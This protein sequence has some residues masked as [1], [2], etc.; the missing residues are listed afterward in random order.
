MLALVGALGCY[1]MSERVK[2]LAMNEVLF[3]EMNER[4]EERVQSSAGSGTSFE[5]VCECANIDCAQRITLTATEYEQAHADPTQF[6]IVPGHIAVDIEEVVTHNEHF[7][8]VR[9]QGLAGDVAEA[10]D[11]P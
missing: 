8:V 2:R 4:V 7:E 10:I 5:I 1:P 3:R 11:K 6:T 9:K